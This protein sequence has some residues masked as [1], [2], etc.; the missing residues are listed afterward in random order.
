M[1]WNSREILLLGALCAAPAL[2][3]SDATAGHVF[4][5]SNGKVIAATSTEGIAPIE[6]SA[7]SGHAEQG[8]YFKSCADAWRAGR[9][10][11]RA[12]SPGYRTELDGDLDGIACEPMRR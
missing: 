10:P 2:A 8:I 6:L 11:I 12:G 1:L 9:A 7:G 4:E 3:Q 5:I